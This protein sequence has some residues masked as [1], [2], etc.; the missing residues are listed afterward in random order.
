MY[1][2]LNDSCPTYPYHVFNFVLPPQAEVEAETAREGVRRNE[3]IDLTGADDDEVGLDQAPHGGSYDLPV[4]DVPNKKASLNNFHGGGTANRMHGISLYQPPDDL[5]SKCQAIVPRYLNQANRHLRELTE[6]TDSI[7]NKSKWTKHKYYEEISTMLQR[8]RDAPD[9]VMV[10]NRSGEKVDVLLGLEGEGGLYTYR[11]KMISTFQRLGVCDHAKK[12]IGVSWYLSLDQIPG[13]IRH[14]LVH[15]AVVILRT[16]RG[17]EKGSHGPSFQH[18]GGLLGVD[19]T[20]LSASK[21]EDDVFRRCFEA[22]ATWRASCTTEGCKQ[23]ALRFYHRFPAG[24]FSRLAAG[25]GIY[26]L[27]KNWECDSCQGTDFELVNLYP[28]AM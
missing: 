25:G 8:L 18:M 16:K 11:P 19:P 6:T 20:E 3:P 22:A 17:T 7:L 5:F 24:V 26:K 12:A 21:V 23:P 28:N 4:D 10:E 13:V 27:L 15:A 1:P 14:E 2:L 9:T